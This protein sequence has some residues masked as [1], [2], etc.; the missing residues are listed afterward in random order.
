[1]WRWGHKMRTFHSH[2][3]GRCENILP[4]ERINLILEV[5][6]IVWEPKWPWSGLRREDNTGILLLSSSRKEWAYFAWKIT[7]FS[8]AECFP[9]KSSS[10]RAATNTFQIT[11]CTLLVVM[12]SCLNTCGTHNEESARRFIRCVHGVVKYPY[13]VMDVDAGN[14]RVGLV[15]W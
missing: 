5:S 11:N 2:T 15:I 12:H 6:G 9:P 3:Q 13:P 10:G 8:R 7:T 1:M 4:G 14:A